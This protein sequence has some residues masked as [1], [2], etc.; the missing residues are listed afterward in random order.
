MKPERKSLAELKSEHRAL[1]IKRRYLHE[2]IDLLGGA[3]VLKPDAAARLERYH[4]TE[5]KVSRQRASLYRLIRE[6]Q[7]QS[8]RPEQN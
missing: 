4:A 3:A 7:K 1:C 8:L 2:S 6:S 5:R